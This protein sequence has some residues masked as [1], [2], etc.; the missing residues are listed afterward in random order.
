M[1]KLTPSTAEA[2]S[3]LHCTI[4]AASLIQIK[5]NAAERECKTAWQ[6]LWAHFG[7]ITTNWVPGDDKVNNIK[8]SLWEKSSLERKS[9]YFDMLH[10]GRGCCERLNTGSNLL[11]TSLRGSFTVTQQLR[12]H[13]KVND[14]DFQRSKWVM[15]TVILVILFGIAPATLMI[16]K[17]PLC[18]SIATVHA[19][20]CLFC[21]K[22]YWLLW[23][24]PN[25]GQHVEGQTDTHAGRTRNV[26]VTCGFLS[27]LA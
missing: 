12:W 20:I 8:G 7:S 2:P 16:Q 10:R 26:N 15:N 14:N 4:F 27:G 24:L 1:W 22:Q 3:C 6:H 19:L 5:A 17:A 21:C 23:I 25:R 11:F 9:V 13:Y 18:V